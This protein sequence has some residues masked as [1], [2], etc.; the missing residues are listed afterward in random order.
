MISDVENRKILFFFH[1]QIFDLV[2]TMLA[3]RDIIKTR[4]EINY[5]YM[6]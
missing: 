3:D 4:Q 6:T 1:M 2:V 5:T